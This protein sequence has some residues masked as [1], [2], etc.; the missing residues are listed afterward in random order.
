MKRKLEKKLVQ[1]LEQD[2]SALLITG[3]RQV[4]K[5]HLVRDVLSR[6]SKSHIEINFIENERASQLFNGSKSTKDIL[7]RIS[8][9]S[10]TQIIP[11]ETVIFLDEIQEC[12][13]V[14]TWIKFLVEDG[15]YKYV[16][17]GSLLG[18]EL[19]DFRSAP[20]GSMEV[21]DM[22]PMDLE[23]FLFALNIKADTWNY[24]KKCFQDK[25]EVDE[26]IHARLMEA[27]Y[28]YLIIGGM[29]EAVQTYIDTNNIKKVENVH[30]KILRLYKQDF[31]KYENKNKLSLRETYDCI[32]SELGKGNKRFRIS[33]IAG[34]INYDRVKNDYIW[35]KNAGV[36]LPV[37][38]IEELKIPLKSNEKRSLF[39]LYSSDVG[40]LTSQYSGEAKIK[41]LNQDSDVNNGAIF[42]NAIIQE[43]AS[44]GH[45]IYYS[46]NKKGELDAVIEIDGKVLV[47]EAKSGTNYKTH[48]S[49]SK[50][51]ATK[52]YDIKKAYVLC[53]GNVE[54]LDNIVYLPVYMCAF[55]ENMELEKNIKKLD[56]SDI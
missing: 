49:L 41:I 2:N 14:L 1:W 9:I 5:T 24:V 4:G 13:D 10:D 43:L 34:K 47:I 38:N 45:Q 44:K 53:K 6:Y 18:V 42:E 29:P 31:S 25:K 52:N 50:I 12:P 40:L 36:V 7:L 21:I 23:E 20:V 33:H 16:L 37:Y 56:L 17:S 8:A 54:V 30:Q 28:L 39:K 15:T 22:Y 55:I 46:D 3:A 19:K 35:L 48:A 32:P 26:F 51:L 27:F 11:H